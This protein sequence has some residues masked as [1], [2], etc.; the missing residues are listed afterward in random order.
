M[1]KN[2]VTKTFSTRRNSTGVDKRNGKKNYEQKF[3]SGMCLNAIIIY[4][5]YEKK[6]WTCKPESKFFIQTTTYYIHET[7]NTQFTFENCGGCLKQIRKKNVRLLEP[8]KYNFNKQWVWSNK[9]SVYFWE[10]RRSFKTKL[11][12]DHCNT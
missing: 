6:C 1:Q 9:Y 8:L 12:I 4:W 10:Q 2:V 3:V 5:C 7:T 11:K